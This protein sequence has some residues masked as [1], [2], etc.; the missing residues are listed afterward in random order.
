MCKYE[1]HNRES[2][3]PNQMSK[4]V[5]SKKKI[6]NAKM[7]NECATVASFKVWTDL[8]QRSAPTET[9]WKKREEVEGD[10][11]WPA[12][13]AANKQ[14][15]WADDKRRSG[16]INAGSPGGP[17]AVSKTWWKPAGWLWSPDTLQWLAHRPI[18]PEWK[19]SRGAGA[20]S[21]LT[22]QRAREEAGNVTLDVE[23]RHW[24]QRSWRRF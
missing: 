22:K 12:Q 16:R 4:H 6:E 23:T 1:R 21:L 19:H 11:T 2:T 15:V 10:D 14:Q 24:Q 3:F 13:D 8:R 18:S 20:E 9:D 17:R 7:N 5:G